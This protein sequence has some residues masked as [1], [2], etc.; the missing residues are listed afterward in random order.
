MISDVG[1]SISELFKKEVI[2]DVRFREDRIAAKFP[3]GGVMAL[4]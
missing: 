1:C 3:P 2:S 4:T